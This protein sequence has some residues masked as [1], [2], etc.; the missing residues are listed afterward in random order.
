MKT[1]NF[2][3]YPLS[4]FLSVLGSDSPAPGGGS[5]AAL[6][7]S[8]GIALVEMV[9]RINAKRNAKNSKN[10]IDTLRRLRMRA[11]NLITQDAKA[12]MALSRVFK[13]K[14]KGARFQQALKVGARVPLEIC[15]FSSQALSIALLEKN[16]TSRWLASDLVEAALLLEAAFGS[17]RL[18][19]EINLGQI[20]DKNFVFKIKKRLDFLEHKVKKNARKLSL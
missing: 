3:K 1:F 2:S 18:N 5:A 14:R 12:F 16:R 20:T 6:V 10:R 19:V 8:L 9:A 7:A 15:E 11:E 17:G 13:E 4:Q